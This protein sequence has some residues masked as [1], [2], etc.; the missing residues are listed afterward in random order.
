MATKKKKTSEKRSGSATL[1]DSVKAI[2]AKSKPNKEKKEAKKNGRPIEFNKKLSDEICLRLKNGESLRAIC[3][4]EAM[5]HISTIFDWIQKSQE[6]IKPYAGF[7]EQYARARE[8]QADVLFDECA[9]I[10]DQGKADHYVDPET[11]ELRVDGDAIQRAK[12]RIE[13]RRWMAEKMKPKK[14][15]DKILHG[16]DP[17]NPLPPAVANTTIKFNSVEEAGAALDELIKK[18]KG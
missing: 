16:S 18:S 9:D 13:T 2:V 7:S 11:G 1:G 10:A 12:L 14:Y 8:V 5:P 6:C 4:D 15:G 17:E 3:R